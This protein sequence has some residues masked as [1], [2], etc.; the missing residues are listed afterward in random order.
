M[1]ER[2]AYH[3][4]LGFCMVV[5]WLLA[6]VLGSLLGGAGSGGGAFG[7]GGFG[8]GGSAQYFPGN[9]AE[10]SAGD[11]SAKIDP[12]GIAVSVTV[13]DDLRE[14]SVHHGLVTFPTGTAEWYLTAEGNIGLKPEGEDYQPS[15]AERAKFLEELG[16]IRKERGF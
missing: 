15:D 5:A 14:G 9:P 13:A 16:R 7:A 1:G 10:A 3:A 11:G 2:L 12:E 8:G 4:S 6:G